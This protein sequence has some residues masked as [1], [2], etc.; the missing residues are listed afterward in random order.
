M[1]S[2]KRFPCKCSSFKVQ[3]TEKMQFIENCRL[4]SLVALIFSVNAWTLASKTHRPNIA[5]L[6][7]LDTFRLAAPATLHPARHSR[8]LSKNFR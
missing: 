5:G 7:S 4:N 3:F 8:E 6:F 2:L 1:L